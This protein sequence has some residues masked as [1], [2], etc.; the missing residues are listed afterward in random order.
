M[1]KMMTK[2]I[3]HTTV[4]LARIV[5]V[6]GQPKSESLEDEILLGNVSLEQAQRTINKKLGAG[7]T[8]FEV[9]PET[10]VYEMPVEEFIVLASIR[11]VEAE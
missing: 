2:E 8:V 9:Q 7:V 6:D 3:T 5:V 1:R 11:E 4:K 10:K